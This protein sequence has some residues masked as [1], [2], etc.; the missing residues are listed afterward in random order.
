MESYCIPIF[1]FSAFSVTIATTKQ[2][3]NLHSESKK[4]S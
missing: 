2:A 1:L 4:L 3:T